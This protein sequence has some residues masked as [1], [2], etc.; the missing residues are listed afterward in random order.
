VYVEARLIRVTRITAMF[1]RVSVVLTCD[2]YK[3]SLRHI[4]VL[5]LLLLKVEVICFFFAFLC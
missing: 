4:H 3:S 5:V 2:M 1:L